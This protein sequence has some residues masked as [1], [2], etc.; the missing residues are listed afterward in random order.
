MP[1]EYIFPPMFL[2]ALANYIV[3][4]SLPVPTSTITLFGLFRQHFD[5]EYKGNK[6]YYS[7]LFLVP[8]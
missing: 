8:E 3:E 2:A 4:K 5:I 1:K 7:E 6:P